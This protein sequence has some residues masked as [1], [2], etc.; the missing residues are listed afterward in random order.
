MDEWDSNQHRERTQYIHSENPKLYLFEFG[1]QE[2]GKKFMG[3]NMNDQF[4]SE[5]CA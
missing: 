3:K 5:P 2:K 1:I 4:T